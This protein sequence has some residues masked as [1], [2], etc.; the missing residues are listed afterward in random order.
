MKIKC[1]LNELLDERGI[2]KRFIAKKLKVSPP[3]VTAWSNDTNFIP[4]DKAFEIADILGCKVDDL[5]KRE[6]E[7]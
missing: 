2:K 6:R 5:Y 3:T 7:T 4:M 1:R